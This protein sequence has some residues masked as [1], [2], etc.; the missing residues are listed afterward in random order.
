MWATWQGKQELVKVL[1]QYG[2]DPNYGTPIS[3]AHGFPAIR[4]LLLDAGADPKVLIRRG[5]V[6]GNLVW[7]AACSNKP[8]SVAFWL[9]Y[10]LDPNEEGLTEPLVAAVCTGNPESVKLLLERGKIHNCYYGQTH[11]FVWYPLGVGVSG[12]ASY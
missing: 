8:E 3:Y 2:A 12:Q 9:N 7:D 11:L 10:G 5:S 4:Q 1:L 6:T